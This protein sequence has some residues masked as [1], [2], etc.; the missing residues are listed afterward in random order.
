MENRRVKGR[1][2]EILCQRMFY[3]HNINPITLSRKSIF[4]VLV[5]QNHGN[6]RKFINQINSFHRDLVSSYLEKHKF[7]VYEREECVWKKCGK[8]HEKYFKPAFDPS[9]NTNNP[10]NGRLRI[11][12]NNQLQMD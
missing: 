12:H 10:N 7:I 8:T 11:K 9:F 6:R 1:S 3:V 4:A 5:I 2:I